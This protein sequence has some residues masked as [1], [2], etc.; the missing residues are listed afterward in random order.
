RTTCRRR[1]RK[2]RVP[3]ASG[4]RRSWT[5]QPRF[6]TRSARPCRNTSPARSARFARRSSRITTSDPISRS[7]VGSSREGHRRRRATLAYRGRRG[8]AVR[9]VL[10]TFEGVEGSGKTTQMARLGRWL[11][12]RG[13]R[14]ELTREPDGTPLGV[15]IRRLFER[16]PEPLTEVFL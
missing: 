10:I 1:T 5:R 2:T 3:P 12:Q 4:R 6:R 7:S 11:K 15:G 16:S 13:Y 14:V 9:G 8:V